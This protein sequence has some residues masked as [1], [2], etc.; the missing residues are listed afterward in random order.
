MAALLDGWTYITGDEQ[1][2]RRPVKALL[3]AL[4]ELGA[5]AWTARPGVDAC[6]VVVHGPM[7]GGTARLDGLFS[8][9]VS[10]ILMSAPLLENDTEILVENP[11][12]RPYLDLTLDWMKRYGV[13]AERS[14]DYRR[15]FVRGGQRYTP[16]DTVIA[17]DWSAAAFP[18][19]AALVTGSTITIESLDYN[20]GHGD[21]AV[22]DFLVRMGAG[23]EQDP[24]GNRLVVRGDGTLSS[25]IRIDLRD[26]P[27]ALPALAVAAARAEGDTLFSGL[28]VTRLKETDR[29]QV[30]ASELTKM[31]AR[32]E[33]DADTMTVHGGRELRGTLVESHG[34][35]RVAMALLICGLASGGTTFVKDAECAEVSFPAFFQAMSALGASFKTR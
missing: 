17:G 31:G 16:A 29:V 33:C 3:S 24:A 21:K 19:V 32:I 10:S 14:A 2:R 5:R 6:P 23:I 4:G 7:K 15:F 1:I 9:Y 18:A 30:M 20:D 8:Q 28:A 25:G 34:D 26:C 11:G 13:T 12:E 35:H 22:L 27:D